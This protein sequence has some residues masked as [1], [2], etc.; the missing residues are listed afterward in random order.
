M[1]DILCLMFLDA[2]DIWQVEL[3]K[4]QRDSV[5][6]VLECIEQ[7]WCVRLCVRIGVELSYLRRLWF[8]HT[9]QWTELSLAP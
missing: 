5:F 6:F 8:T 7:V 3:N 1:K 2:Y 4:D 9:R